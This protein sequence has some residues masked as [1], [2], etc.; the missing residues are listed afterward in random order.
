MQNRLKDTIKKP[1][2]L[3]TALLK[4]FA[5]TDLKRK[6]AKIC[7]KIVNEHHLRMRFGHQM[8]YHQLRTNDL[9][10]LDLLS[11]DNFIKTFIV[12]VLTVNRKI[13]NFRL[14]HAG[15]FKFNSASRS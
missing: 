7:Y 2:Y 4:V 10:L 3:N 13:Y 8:I 9:K 14:L 15:I 12:L 1:N 11:I 5:L 6:I